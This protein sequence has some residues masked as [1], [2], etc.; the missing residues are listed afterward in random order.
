MEWV[1]RIL[2]SHLTVPSH[3]AR[4]DAEL[5]QLLRATI[6][7]AVLANAPADSNLE[8]NH[9]EESRDG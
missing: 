6:R 9:R 7:P 2:M 4:T 8:I 5:R 1:L 3:L